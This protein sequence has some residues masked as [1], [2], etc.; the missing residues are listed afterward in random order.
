MIACRRLGMPE[1]AIQC[2]A[3]TLRRMRYSV[4]HTYGTSQQEYTGS[5]TEP[6]FGTGQG[7]GASPAI[8][9]GLVVIVL[10]ALDRISDE[11]EIPGL[12]FADPCNDVRTKWRV[13]AFVDDTN[14]DIM[15]S[16]GSLS[17]DELV[18]Q[19]RRAGQLWETLLHISGGSLNLAKCSWTLQYWHWIKGRPQLLPL[20][21]RDPLLL[22]TSG[23]SP[24]H[25][26]IRQHSNTTEVKGLGVHMNFMGTFALHAT[27]MRLKFD[28]MARR[29][30]QSSLSP[31]LLRKF[32]NTFYLQSVRYSLP[33][34]SMTR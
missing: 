19:L 18:D 14:Q 7:S 23:S 15:D 13:G 8:W 20:T 21:P 24:E 10:N 2:Q 27:T 34:T 25:H 6:L 9:L 12:D 32:Y 30:R 16:K 22:M 26:I 28:G 1:H 17:I 33:V 4:K 29:L 5:P 11:D 31:A 3:E